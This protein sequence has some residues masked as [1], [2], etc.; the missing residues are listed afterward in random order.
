MFASAKSPVLTPPSRLLNATRAGW[1]DTV[2]SLSS[3]SV[4]VPFYSQL[5]IGAHGATPPA[6]GAGYS[7]AERSCAIACVTMLLDYHG[8]AVP[9]DHVLRSGVDAGG[10]DLLLGWRHTALVGVLTSFGLTAYRRNW[11]LLEGREEQYL[12][13]RPLDPGARREIE[14]VKRQ[15]L[16][17]GIW[18]LSRLVAADIPVIVSVYRPW[19]DSSSPGHQVVLLG[20]DE[21]CVT[22]HDPALRS[23]AYSR[24]PVADFFAS[25]KGTAIMAHGRSPGVNPSTD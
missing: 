8:R 5:D 3:Q 10:F 24:Y 2:T 7:W 15:Q 22:F 20:R 1:A 11:R 25:W 6:P 18:T 17:E 4:K 23:G 9:A 12:A 19:G 13:G 21:E 16:E 14:F